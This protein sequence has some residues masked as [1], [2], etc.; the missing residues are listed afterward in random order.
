M[1]W[2]KIEAANNVYLEFRHSSVKERKEL[3]DK[4]VEEYK[5]ENKIL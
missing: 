3:L 2:K 1:M 5:I 4:I